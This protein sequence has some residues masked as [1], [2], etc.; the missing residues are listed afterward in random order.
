MGAG[1]RPQD[2]QPL[3]MSFYGTETVVNPNPKLEELITK[4]PATLALVPLTIRRL[5]KVHLQLRQR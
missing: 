3:T 2:I 1:D 4:V 5:S